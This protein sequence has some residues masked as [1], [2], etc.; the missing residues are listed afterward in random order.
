MRLVNRFLFIVVPLILGAL[1]GCSTLSD[2][3]TS[4]PEGAFKLGEK[5]EKDERFEEAIAQFS[6]VKNKHPYSRL[7]TAAELKIAD[8]HFKREEFIEAQN[9][10]QVFK[11]LHPSHSRI[12]YVTYRLGLSFYMQLPGTIDRDLAVAERAILYFDEVIQSF[13]S[14]QYVKD[15]R[16][17]KSKA[18]RM[19]ADK[20]LYVANFYFIRD[21]FES[22]L[23]RYEGLL[24]RYPNHGVDPQAL[25]GAAVS[26]FKMKELGK[27]KTYYQ[28]LTSRFKNSPEAAKARSEIGDRI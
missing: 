5:F 25:Y 2:I 12:D 19:L 3:D 22:A 1:L 15:A 23:S 27:A 13:S 11:E 18:L 21:H 9:A 8:I 6:Q 14:S 20:E 7:A 16:E 17:H 28:R 24:D 26:A 4:T 10:Y